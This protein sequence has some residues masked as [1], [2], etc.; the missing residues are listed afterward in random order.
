MGYTTYFTGEVSVDPPLNEDEVSFLANFC[1]TRRMHRRA[2]PL[3]IRGSGYAGQGNDPDILDSNMPDPDQPGLWCHWVAAEDGK[4][5]EWDGSEKFYDSADWMLYLINYLFSPAAKPYVAAHVGEDE[6]LRNFTC[7]HTFDGTIYAVGEDSDDRWKLTI[8][9]NVLKV[10][11]A[12]ITYGDELDR[13]VSQE[14]IDK[15][16][17]SITGSTGAVHLWTLAIRDGNATVASLHQS[18]TEAYEALR[19][20]YAAD[21]AP[22]DVEALVNELEV[23]GVEYVIDRHEMLLGTLVQKLEE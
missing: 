19:Q 18:Q 7:D 1:A 16:I 6:R 4:V 9:N 22:N 10:F 12:T 2:G 20:N 17:A 8:Q 23:Q 3:F 13:P 14:E 15:A 5:I 21:L 11:E